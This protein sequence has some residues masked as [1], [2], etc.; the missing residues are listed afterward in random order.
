MSL[1]TYLIVTIV[2]L[3]VASLA[4]VIALFWF[5]PLDVVVDSS[6][7][8]DHSD[9]SDDLIHDR[10]THEETTTPVEEDT[11][12]V[13]E[14]EK[15][16]SAP[17]PVVSE[18]RLT[19]HP[20]AHPENN[21]YY[22]DQM[23]ANGSF[24]VVTQRSPGSIHVYENTNHKTTVDM[25]D[26]TDACVTPD[27]QWIATNGRSL[28][29]PNWTAQT[30]HHRLSLS[31]SGKHVLVFGHPGVEGLVV[32]TSNGDIVSN[33]AYSGAC[34]A[35][36]TDR[37]FVLG[38]RTYEMSPSVRRDLGVADIPFVDTYHSYVSVDN[39]HVLATHSHGTALIELDVV[40][41]VID[42]YENVLALDYHA[43]SGQ[44]LAKSTRKDVVYVYNWN[45]TDAAFYMHG[46]LQ[47]DVPSFGHSAVI[48]NKSSSIVS[49]PK[50]CV[51]IQCSLWVDGE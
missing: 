34:G 44:L 21:D 6:K 17:L 20:A 30:R 51:A 11:T 5:R 26:V 36:L 18:K 38:A 31:P 15:E 1:H 33:V 4:I 49:A 29:S 47:S 22:G 24:V 10:T 2:G 46:V 37:R 19:V 43:Y 9:T 25:L 41:S 16:E 3:I 32:D 48:L 28:M 42:D 27:G 13:D 35:W 8:K 50:M 23:H 39:K 45:P 14:E 40:T 7:N 12:P